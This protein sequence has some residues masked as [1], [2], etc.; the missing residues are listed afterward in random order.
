M[1]KRSKQSDSILLDKQLLTLAEMKRAR[2][3]S[4]L[5][6]SDF[7]PRN[8]IGERAIEATARLARAQIR[9]AKIDRLVAFVAAAT[10]RRLDN[11][12][13]AATESERIAN[14]RRFADDYRALRI[15]NPT[16]PAIPEEITDFS[17]ATLRAPQGQIGGGTPS[18]SDMPMRSAMKLRSVSELIPKM[19]RQDIDGDGLLALLSAWRHAA[20]SQEPTSSARGLPPSR[21][22]E[23]N[24][25]ASDAEDWLA[26]RSMETDAEPGLMRYSSSLAAAYEAL[27]DSDAQPFDTNSNHIRTSALETKLIRAASGRP[28]RAIYELTEI[29]TLIA[30]FTEALRSNI[31]YPPTLRSPLAGQ[32]DIARR[33]ETIA[34]DLDPLRLGLSDNAG[35]GAPIVGYDNVVESG[36]ARVLALRKRYAGGTGGNADYISWLEQ[37]GYDTAGLR[38]PILIARRVSPLRPAERAAFVQEAN[39][40]NATDGNAALAGIGLLDGLA[41]SADPDVAGIGSALAIAAPEWHEMRVAAAVGKLPI[42]LDITADIRRLLRALLDRGGPAGPDNQEIEIE[43]AG[44]ATDGMVAAARLLCRSISPL[45]LYEPALVLAN[46]RNFLNWARRYGETNLRLPIEKPKRPFSSARRVDF[47]EFRAEDPVARLRRLLAFPPDP[48]API[49]MHSVA[50]ELANADNRVLAAAEIA[51]SA[52]NA[53]A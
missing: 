28:I 52:S 45:R 26:E 4:S 14:L 40:G 47:T 3:R 19:Q 42:E 10:G 37:Q 24:E 51:N 44:P 23:L 22:D 53:R 2:S 46:F 25:A 16:L 38:Q 6:E 17:E 15:Q 11:P 49:D 31:A 33:V 32:T 1:M 20:E 12:L 21:I 39:E 7:V 27:D 34:N 9:H 30:A 35:Y 50:T 43:R 5:Q 41:Q 29:P 18:Q 13:V 36:T 48:R 8:N